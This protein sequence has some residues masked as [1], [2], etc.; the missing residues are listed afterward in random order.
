MTGIFDSNR[1]T[2]SVMPMTTICGLATDDLTIGAIANCESVWKWAA[3]PCF[4]KR[5]HC[6][7]IGWQNG[8]GGLMIACLA[9][10]NVANRV[11]NRPWFPGQAP[12][13]RTGALKLGPLFV[14]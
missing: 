11:W 14:I 6:C 8:S 10:L 2:D 5:A 9:L 7:A 3:L 4:S 1:E 13:M 12:P